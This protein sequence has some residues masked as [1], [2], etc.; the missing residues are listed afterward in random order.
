MCDRTPPQLPRSRER[1]V[2]ADR[3][4]LIPWHAL[5]P[6]VPVQRGEMESSPGSKGRARHGLPDD[7]ALAL[8]GIV[9]QASRAVCEIPARNIGILRKSCRWDGKTHSQR[10]ALSRQ[11]STIRRRAQGQGQTPHAVDLHCRDGWGRLAAG[12]PFPAA[13]LVTD[14]CPGRVDRTA[15]RRPSRT[16][17]VVAVGF[18]GQGRRASER[19]R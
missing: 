14:G 8:L 4:G 18:G 11:R 6:S 3:H 19:V 12:G 17:G 1:L 9:P 10:A 7:P 2:C 13:P 5:Q 16:P 15:T